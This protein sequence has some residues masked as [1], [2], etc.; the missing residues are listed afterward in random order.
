MGFGPLFIFIYIE[1]VLYKP[2]LPIT[3]AAAE[4]LTK[5]LNIPHH[6]QV[7]SPLGTDFTFMGYDYRLEETF[8]E[9]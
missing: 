2:Y 6:M 3:Q 1:K 4:W 9:K 7:I 8:R 5:R